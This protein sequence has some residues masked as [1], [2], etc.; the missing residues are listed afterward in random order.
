MV[1][2]GVEK[3]E[4]GAEEHRAHRKVEKHSQAPHPRVVE[5]VVEGFP[6]EVE[7]QHVVHGDTEVGS[8][9]EAGSQPRT[10]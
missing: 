5:L 10:Q 8:N 2:H 1:N 3:R 7:G 9:Q 6:K 4:H